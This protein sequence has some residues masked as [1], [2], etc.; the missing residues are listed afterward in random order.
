MKDY[1]DY[2]LKKE[3]KPVNFDKICKRIE[4]L[5]QKNHIKQQLSFQDKEEIKT[6]LTSGVEKCDYYKTP[7]NYYT[8][9][10]KTSFRKG[11]FFANRG[12]DGFVTTISA[13]ITKDGEHIVKEHK[14]PITKDKCNY[15]LDG[16][17][18][19]I[20][21]GGR[22]QKPSVV[23]VL[24]RNV[25]NIVGEI[26]RNGSQFYVQPLDK[27]QRII[28]IALEGENYIPGEI[29]SVSL[30][31][32]R[33]KNFYI[34]TVL[35]RFHHKYDPR[36]DILLEAFRKGMPDGFSEDSL[37]QEAALPTSI[38]LK[39]KIGRFDFTNWPVI[40]IDGSDVKDKDDCISYF[41]LPNGNM[42]YAAHI[43]D[44][45][46]FVPT[47]SPIHLDAFRKGNSYYFGGCV[48]P[49][50]PRKLSCGICS[51]EHDVERLTKT[52]LV[53]YDPEGN[54][55]RR[56]Y[57]KGVINSRL[58]MSYE[59][60]NDYFHEGIADDDYLPFTT[61]LEMMK[62]FAER[63]HDKRV[64]DG[65]IQFDIPE[66]R[67]IYE[68]GEAVDVDFRIHDIAEGIIEELMLEANTH[69]IEIM[70]ESGCPVI[71]RVHGSPNEKRLN[72]LLKYLDIIDM[73]FQYSAEEI[74]LDHKKLQL[75]T[76]HINQSGPLKTVLNEQLRDCMSP[77]YYSTLNRGHYGTGKKI[78]GHTTSPERRLSDDTNSRI[79]D[80]CYFVNGNDQYLQDLQTWSQII[81]IFTE[82]GSKITPID[83]KSTAKDREDRIKA[84]QMWSEQA[85][86]FAEQAS[87]MERVADAVERS[88]DQMDAASV[89]NHHK[90]EE[91][92][93][94]VI[95]VDSFGLTVM[96]DN[97]I[98]GHVRTRFLK[99]EFVF[100]Q[101]TFTLV[102]IDDMESYYLGDRLK[103]RLKSA[104]R[105]TKSIDFYISEKV[106]EN[107]VVNNSRSNAY[108]KQKRLEEMFAKIY[109]A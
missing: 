87:T 70:K 86:I 32:E 13:F 58:A 53:E 91:F 73:P 33:S 77:A 89:M 12:G 106:R 65:A 19:L 23:R 107:P 34:G 88:V 35:R 10:T 49:Q 27:K 99:G 105:E 103:L 8:L 101:D 38:S 22:G 46:Y 48:E 52:T 81:P 92:E 51:L 14:Y 4:V 37:E 100:N 50:Y 31:E 26:I 18:V 93:G 9:L 43:V 55:V 7:N 109:N 62:D 71:Y 83:Y 5:F 28:T 74:C 69:T 80:D 59:K 25:V 76:E 64:Q 60:V 94:T 56:A 36:A 72:N 2:V 17:I 11:R 68:N 97:Y 21:I 102:S 67:F 3:K 95:D 98:K 39:D 42:L 108:V 85:P 40:S 61:T 1:I 47:G 84:I 20:D 45:P 30:G 104:R 16:D 63:L 54:V 79:A 66:P 29:V 75:L 41:K 15:A 90:A 96:L 44:S 82:E 57:V 6:I 24:E 78:Y